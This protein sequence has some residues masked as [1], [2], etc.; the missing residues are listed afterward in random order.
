[1]IY[2]VRC[3]SRLPKRASMRFPAFCYQVQGA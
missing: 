2:Q 3:G 1:M